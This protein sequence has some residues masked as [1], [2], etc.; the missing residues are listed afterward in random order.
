MIIA[1]ISFGTEYNLAP[2]MN[3]GYFM[4]NIKGSFLQYVD[5]MELEQQMHN[6]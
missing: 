1:I 4:F 2:T 5:E 6:Q 3:D